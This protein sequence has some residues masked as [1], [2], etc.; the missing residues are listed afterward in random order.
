M[1]SSQLPLRKSNQVTFYRFLVYGYSK[2]LNKCYISI[3]FDIFINHSKTGQT[4]TKTVPGFL[5]I[6]YL[7][8]I[9]EQFILFDVL[10]IYS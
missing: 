3:S 9:Q 1:T 5:G 10:L 7:F 4:M 6:Y 8:E 2:F